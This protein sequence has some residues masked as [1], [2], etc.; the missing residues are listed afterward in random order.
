MSYDDVKLVKLIGGELVLGEWTEGSQVIKNPAIL[1]TVPTQQGVSMMLMPYGYPF[2][3]EIEGE[4]DARHVMYV[5]KT[6]PSELA[7]KY[8]EAK[9]N[10]TLSGPGDLQTLNDLAQSAGGDLSTLLKK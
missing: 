4:I 6:Y 3:T 2:E 9:S 1:Q 10:L 5:Y 7:T 8:M